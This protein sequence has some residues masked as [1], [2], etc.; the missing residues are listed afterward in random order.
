MKIDLTKMRC[1]WWEDENGNVYPNTMD[2]APPIGVIYYHRQYP[3]ELNHEID[4]YD[5][6]PKGID[7][8]LIKLPCFKNRVQKR[9]G[10]TF[11]HLAT[12]SSTYGSGGECIVAM[13]NSGDYT[14]EQ[15]IW[16]YANSCERCMNVLLHKYLNGKDGYPEHSEEWNK[17]NTECDF[18]REDGK[19]Q[20]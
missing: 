10:R 19:E 4:V 5:F 17:C 16:V 7:K 18:C 11:K 14:L 12:F 15:A 20:E 2:E 13:V 6:H 3:C 8:L 1:T 9:I